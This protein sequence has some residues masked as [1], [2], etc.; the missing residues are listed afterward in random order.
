MQRYSI[1]HLKYVY[2]LFSKK[3]PYYT[4]FI[5]PDERKKIDLLAPVSNWFQLPVTLDS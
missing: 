5:K 4:I 1:Q 2:T 3:V